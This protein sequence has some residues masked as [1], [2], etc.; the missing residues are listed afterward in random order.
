MRRVFIGILLAV[1]LFMGA[2]VVVFRHFLELS[3]LDAVYF[4][5]ATMT[6]VGY[7]D[8]NLSGAPPFVKVF[9]MGTMLGGAALMASVFGI[10]TD[11][12][13]R[14]RFEEIFGFRGRKM[15]NHIILCG[16]GNVGIRVLEQ[17]HRL[18]EPVIVIEKDEQSRF[19]DM[20]KALK[21]PIIHGDMRVPAMLE[22]A[23]IKD[24]KALIAAAQDDMA[25]LEAA[26][27]ARAVCPGIRVVVRIFD[28]NLA[29]KL[30]GVFGFKSVFST[31]ALAA[32]GFAMAAI[33]PGVVGSFYVGDALMTNVE[34][35]VARGCR[36]EG[37]T[38]EELRDLGDL[39]VLSHV[40][41]KTGER[42]L[43]PS[44]AVTLQ[45]GDRI[46]VSTTQEHYRMV[47]GLCE[48]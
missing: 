42:R 40:S 9:G 29:R 6:T 46:V 2:S 10:I 21:V 8:I 19:I 1:A 33:D 5:V 41:G 7:G 44:D 37:M 13:V 28:T 26:L 25:N 27:N 11:Y 15:R 30:E 3:W 31:S 34:L 16:L 22:Q 43:H 32:P 20:G 4:T 23:H 48:V 18:G 35:V 36:L 47:K 39:S 45:E 24:A 12:L 17:L 38:T 14:S